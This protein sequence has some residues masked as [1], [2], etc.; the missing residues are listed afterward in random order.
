MIEKAWEADGH[1]CAVAFW[2]ESFHRCGY[3]SVGKDSPLRGVGYFDERLRG[4]SVHGGIT[5]AGDGGFMGAPGMWT[6][7]FDCNHFSDMPDIEHGVELFGD[8]DHVDELR[9]LFCRPASDGFGFVPH[10]WT[11]EEV[12]DETAELSRQLAELEGRL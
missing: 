6:F 12:A 7:G 4:I 1:S 2:R 8:D 10:V 9:R 3:V 11:L 5:Y